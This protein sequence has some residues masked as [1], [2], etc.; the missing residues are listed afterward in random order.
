MPFAAILREV[1]Q[2]QSVS[3]RLVGLAEQHAPISEALLT[4]AGN[5]RNTATILAVLVVAKGPKPI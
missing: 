4:I 2:L 1:D 5:V 3:T